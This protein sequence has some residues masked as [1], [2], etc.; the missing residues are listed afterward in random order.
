MVSKDGWCSVKSS[1][2]VPAK[3]F[4]ESCERSFRLAKGE[5]G[6]LPCS[7]EDDEDEEDEVGSWMA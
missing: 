5:G 7:D 4:H 2:A 3:A 1:F 6:P